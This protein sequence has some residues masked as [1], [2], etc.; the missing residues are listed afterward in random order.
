[1]LGL[2][3]V[4]LQLENQTTFSP[5]GRVPHLLVEVKVLK[6][7]ADFDVTDIFNEISSYLVLLAFG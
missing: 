7:Y 6:T 1:M 5:I 2:S 4:Q 3:P